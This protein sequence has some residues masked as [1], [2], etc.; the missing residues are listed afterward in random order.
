MTQQVKKGPWI[1]DRTLGTGGFGAVTLWR[2]EETGDK[3]AIKRCRLEKEMTEKHRERWQ[4]EVEIMGRL[5]HEN[6]ISAMQVPPHIDVSRDQ[7]P[8]LAMEYCSEGDLRKVLTLPQNCFGLREYSVRCLVHDVASGVEYL[9]AQKIIHRDLKP[10]N[11]VQKKVDDRI[12]YKIIDLGYAKELDQN[13]VCTSFVGTLQYL[14]P[15]LLASQKYTCTVDYWSFGTVVFECI[16]GYRPFLPSSNP[17]QWHREVCKKSPDDICAQLDDSG[18]VK[19]SKTIPSTTRLSRS[20]LTY[21]E[22]WLRN[23]LRWDPKARGGGLAKDNRPACFQMLEN[24]LKM[25]IINLFYVANNELITFPILEQHSLIDL[26][27]RIE[28][29]TQI[30]VSE[31]DI[32]LGSGTSPDVNK[33]A[34]QCWL[35]PTEEDCFVYLFCHSSKEINFHNV[36]KKNN[37]LP[38]SV[39]AIVKDQ[40]AMIPFQEQKKAWAESVYF[41]EEQHYE[42]KRLMLT[43]RAAMLSLLRIDSHFVKLKNKM[44]HELD[45]LMAKTR[46][47][48]ESLEH[49]LMFYSEQANNAGVTSDRMFNKW[50]KMRDEVEGFMNLRDRVAEF[51]SQAVILQTKI[52][53]LQRSPFARPKM[54]DSLLDISKQASK[55]YQDFRQTG[56]NENRDAFKDQKPMVALV[57]KCVMWRN[58]KLPDLFAHLGKISACKLDINSLS[59]Q[60]EKCLQEITGNARKLIEYQK[61]RQTAIWRLLEIAVNQGNKSST[62][63]ATTPGHD[64]LDVGQQMNNIAGGVTAPADLQPNLRMTNATPTLLQ[65]IMSLSGG[66]D[67]LKAVEDNKAT[68]KRFEQ[69]LGDIVQEQDRYS[70]MMSDMNLI[71]SSST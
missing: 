4:L 62:S 33:P 32:I 3:I 28:E 15:E 43:Q 47:F 14:A 51:E 54:D 1:E 2:N 66:G 29:K 5:D 61:Q 30:P 67:S 59:P 57:V 63:Q 26:Q 16:T 52:V 44:T 41:C 34:A 11:I 58:K 38:A 24:V 56:R 25:K 18:Q 45:Q 49:D 21:L 8:L 50:L 69:V 40:T 37:L 19:F 65:S 17:V 46:F 13:S 22:Q 42:F 48:L 55:V 7:L 70:T 53:E 68:A 9:H 27:K 31:Q 6:I 39:Q 35:E 64:T 23:M 60:I 12:V 20:M 10:E 36:Q 71:S